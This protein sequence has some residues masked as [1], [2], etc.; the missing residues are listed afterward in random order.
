MIQKL[1]ALF[2]PAGFFYAFYFGII[3]N[4]GEHVYLHIATNY[5]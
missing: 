1:V 5:N 4:S 2:K 3:T